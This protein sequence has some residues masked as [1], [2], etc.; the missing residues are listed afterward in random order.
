M[1]C[2]LSKKGNWIEIWQ[3]RNI[4]LKSESYSESSNCSILIQTG[5]NINKSYSFFLMKK[6]R[7]EKSLDYKVMYGNDI[8]ILLFLFTF[9]LDGRVKISLV[10]EVVATRKTTKT[11][12]K[13]M[14]HQ[15]QLVLAKRNV[16]QRDQMQQ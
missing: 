14:S 7:K 3:F 9:I 10:E 6:K 15:F 2:S 11:K 12:R 16:R 13:N 8:S 4:S 1:Y 5:H